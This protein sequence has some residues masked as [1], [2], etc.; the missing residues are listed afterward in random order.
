MCVC[1]AAW[2]AVKRVGRRQL[3]VAGRRPW[4][5]NGEEAAAA[6]AVQQKPAR[7]RQ[8]QGWRRRRRTFGL[9]EELL[10][11]VGVPLLGRRG[12]RGRRL[13]LLAP[14]SAAAAAAA[15]AAAGGDVAVAVDDRRR[16]QRGGCGDVAN[17]ANDAYANAAPRRGR[18]LEVEAAV[19]VYGG[20]WSGYRGRVA[21]KRHRRRFCKEK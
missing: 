20:R 7:R 10:D 19:G 15:T 21:E 1:E 3:R 8:K 12:G 11:G 2:G 9:L 18:R 16:A 13:F 6:G 14:A 17:A 5:L 4:L